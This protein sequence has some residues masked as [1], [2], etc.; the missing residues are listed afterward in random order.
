MRAQRSQLLAATLDETRG[1]C[2][3]R[4]AAPD[5]RDAACRLRRAGTGSEHLCTWAS[6]V[7]VSPESIVPL[8]EARKRSGL[9]DQIAFERLVVLT[10]AAAMLPHLPSQP[11]PD[12]VKAM[13]CDEIRRVADADDAVL[14]RAG[15]SGFERLCR[16]ATL[17]R[18]PAGQFEWE[19]SGIPRSDC[20]N[21]GLRAL[22]RVL[23][24]VVF[25]M[26]GF[27]PVFFSHLNPRRIGRPLS[28]DEANRSYYR[29]AQALQRQPDVLGF[30]AC[31]WFR[32]PSTHRISP[33]LGWLSSVFLDNGGMVVEAGPED[34][35]AGP[36]YKSATRRTAYEGGSYLPRRGLVMWPRDAMLAWAARH[37]E[38]AD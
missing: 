14:P 13:I 5:L 27:A 31:S 20:L 23:A 19:V 7:T 22:P 11:V 1:L 8:S 28:E 33:H 25:R 2:D 24:F 29:M 36:L 3:A 30:A 10:A 18:F 37:P 15:T 9:D 12:G 38:L 34:P 26:R 16:L 21:T 35:E 32:A 4:L 6:A 17:R